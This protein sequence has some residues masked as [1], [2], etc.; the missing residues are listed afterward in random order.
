MKRNQQN[1]Q[2]EVEGKIL[3]VP[4]FQVMVI[5]FRVSVGYCH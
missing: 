1:L 4:V 3:S 2:M 5:L